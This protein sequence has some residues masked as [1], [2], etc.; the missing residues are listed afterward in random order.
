MLPYHNYTLEPFKYGH[1]REHAELSTIGCA[2]YTAS[3]PGNMTTLSNK[4]LIATCSM[5]SCSFRPEA[6]KP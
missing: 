3:A 5:A 2:L 1:K 6:L 4:L